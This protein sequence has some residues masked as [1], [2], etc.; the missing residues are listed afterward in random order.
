MAY[1]LFVL[2]YLTDQLFWNSLRSEKGFMAKL[3]NNFYMV[4]NQFGRHFLK[5]DGATKRTGDTGMSTKM[6]SQIRLKF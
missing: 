4:K 5:T 1:N 6:T 3:S 2:K